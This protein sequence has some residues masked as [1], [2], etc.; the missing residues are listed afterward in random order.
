MGTARVFTTRTDAVDKLYDVAPAVFIA[1]RNRLV[2]RLCKE[3]QASVAAA[4]RR[5]PRLPATVWA[6]NRLARRDKGLIDRLVTAFEGLK[7]AHL[8]R[9]TED[10][11]SAEAHLRVVVDVAVDRASRFMREAGLKVSP[12][13]RR[14][15]EETVRGAAVYE[16]EALR[17]G[18]LTQEL[19]APGFD[20]FSS[21][22]LRA[23]PRPP[24]RAKRVALRAIG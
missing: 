6:I 3:G 18:V 14:R 24:S 23:L 16:R 19:V 7:A 15:L 20:L 11:R 1:E 4:V 12:A 2:A 17:E 8:R 22:R 5:R 13:T 21:P 9:W 10:I